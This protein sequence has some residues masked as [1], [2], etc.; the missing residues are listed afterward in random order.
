MMI[1]K[2][3]ACGWPIE[4]PEFMAGSPAKCDECGQMQRLGQR[5][6]DPPE[7]PTEVSGQPEVSKAKN[8]FAT[9]AA[10]VIVLGP[11]LFCI[12]VCSGLFGDV[13]PYDERVIVSGMKGFNLDCAN[14][15]VKQLDA[16]GV[17]HLIKDVLVQPNFLTFGT[18]QKWS[19]LTK[20]EKIKTVGTF[21]QA[22]VEACPSRFNG[23]LKMAG[24]DVNGNFSF[25]YDGP[26]Q[27]RVND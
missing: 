18:N 25:T 15:Y 2:C 5:P 10:A 1:H 9:V 8:I 19:R 16:N 20:A 27:I 21:A 17:G 12:G 24:M 3:R 4:Y 14:D 22:A 7:G 13:E 6:E 11:I 26:N 23:G